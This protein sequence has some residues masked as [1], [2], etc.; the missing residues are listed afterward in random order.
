LKEL[1][2]ARYI[3]YYKVKIDW[4]K[5]KEKYS[6]E[7]KYPPI[8]QLPSA[9]NK[10]REH[11]LEGKNI[12]VNTTGEELKFLMKKYDMEGEILECKYAYADHDIILE[13]IFLDFRKEKK[14]AKAKYLSAKKLR[15]VNEKL[16]KKFLD[17]MINYLEFKAIIHSSIFGKFAQRVSR[18]VTNYPPLTTAQ[19][20]MLSNKGYKTYVCQR[21]NHCI[22]HRESNKKFVFIESKDRLAKNLTSLK[23]QYPDYN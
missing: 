13:K 10:Y 8:F 3:A 15:K 6:D 1:K 7:T 12:T 23:K 2:E 9:D 19:A 4:L 11:L 18:K 14:I 21:C 22:F 20:N 16:E 17:E 5:I